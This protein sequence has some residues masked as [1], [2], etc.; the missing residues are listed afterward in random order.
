MKN[1]KQT[2]AVIWTGQFFSILTSVVVNFGIVLWISMETRSAEMLAYGT[3]AA[4]LPQA[5]LGPV[6]GV[7]IDRWKRKRVMMLADSFIATCTAVLALL[8][9]LDIAQM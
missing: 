2:F 1:W 7:F 9:W 5:L 3:I 4:L 8:F 6:T